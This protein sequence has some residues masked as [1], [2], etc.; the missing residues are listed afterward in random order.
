MNDIPRPSGNE[1]GESCISTIQELASYFS[2]NRKTAVALVRAMADL[3]VSDGLYAIGDIL[4]KG[5]EDSFYLDDLMGLSEE[6]ETMVRTPMIEIATDWD[7]P[8]EDHDFRIS[9]HDF[10]E[11]I[12]VS[13]EL[14]L[15]F[16][17]CLSRECL[18]L[19]E[20]RGKSGPDSGFVDIFGQKVFEVFQEK[21]EEKRAEELRSRLEWEQEIERKR[22]R[23]RL[24]DQLLEERR[25]FER[26]FEQHWLPELERQLASDLR[27]PLD[28][29]H[30][31]L[32]EQQLELDRLLELQENR[33]RD[34][35]QERE[36]FEE[37]HE[38]EK[39]T[40]LRE[41]FGDSIE[42]A[43]PLIAEWM[44]DTIEAEGESLVFNALKGMFS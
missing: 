7:Q 40:M 18:N 23:L 20:E 2:E 31:W 28:Y 11:G 12:E 3:A 34:I 9:V 6:F 4:E 24:L 15:D 8:F 13:E 21:L 43:V 37:E 5:Y 35:D 36:E 17:H 16:G 26:E 10:F 41:V 33:Y 30:H 42:D 14:A 27:D 44:K 19:V 38:Q 29:V 22:G 1:D 25:E 32:I 39:G